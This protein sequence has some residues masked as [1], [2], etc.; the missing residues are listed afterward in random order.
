MNLNSKILLFIGVLLFMLLGCAYFS[1]SFFPSASASLSTYLLLACWS[2]FFAA[3]IAS[4]YHFFLIKRLGKISAFVTDI[5]ERHEFSQRLKVRGNDELAKLSKEINSILEI[6]RASDD[7]IEMLIRNRVLKH[8]KKIDALEKEIVNRALVEKNLLLHNEN[9]IR[10]SRYDTLTSLPNRVLF[11]EVV[12]QSMAITKKNKKILGLLVINLD[13]FKSINDSLGNK[14]GDLVLKELATRFKT[15]LRSGDTLARSGGAEFAILLED[16]VHEEFAGLIAEKIIAASAE[17]IKIDMKTISI[18]SNIGIALYP[19]DGAS[20]EEILN[21]AD[22]AVF[23]AKHST[24]KN[25]QFYFKDMNIETNKLNKLATALERAI[26]DNEFVLYF[27]PRLN[28]KEGNV[29]G[30][31]ALLRWE[32]PVLGHVNP[33]RFMPLAE[34]TGSILQLGEWVLRQA[35]RTSKAWQEQDFQPIPISVNL[36]ASQFK[37]QDIIKLLTTVFQET[38]IDPKLLELEISSST[39]MSDAAISKQLLNAISAMGVQ[40]IIDEF[41]SG[42][43]SLSFLKELPIS[44]LKIDQKFIKGIPANQYDADITKAVIELGRSLG[45]SVIA[46]GVETAEQLQF[47]SDNNCNI[48]QGYLFSKPVSEDAFIANYFKF[49]TNQTPNN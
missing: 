40:I 26:T 41:G 49:Q 23:K 48:G 15:L 39:L 5:N 42:A 2:V 7:Q 14:I 43:T 3:I 16:M 31:E 24:E 18:T 10:L 1:L 45:I 32:S 27:Q 11:N 12:N 20:L 46:T 4:T 28:L 21:N 17:A 47:L 9:L 13:N 33:A 8:Q 30:V 29:L 36:S 34:E 6:A 22:S 38:K 44:I 37:H 35:C 25:Y 19:K